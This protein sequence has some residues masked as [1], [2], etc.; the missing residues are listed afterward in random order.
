[1]FETDRFIVH[2][3]VFQFESLIGSRCST[4]NLVRATF[5]NHCAL[6]NN[7]RANLHG[8]HARMLCGVWLCSLRSITKAAHQA[9]ARTPD[10]HAGGGG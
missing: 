2:K 7:E 4:D 1:L 6:N 8:L 10:A 9:R 3:S 5:L